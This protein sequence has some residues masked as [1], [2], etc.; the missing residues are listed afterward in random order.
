MYIQKFVNV[1]WGFTFLI[2]FAVLLWS[3]AF[4]PERISL[5]GDTL[6][7]AVDR[8]TFFYVAL[9]L[10]VIVNLAAL[11]LRR[12]L[13]ALPL[14]SAVYARNEAF[15]EQLIAWFGG[16]LSAVNVCL[17]TLVG[18]VSLA[19][20]QGSFAISSFNFLV[21]LGPVLMVGC[22]LWLAA[23]LAERRKYVLKG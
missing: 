14:S 7:P 17:I 12:M 16:L 4:L 11:I 21:Y 1:A 5:Y 9:A 15:K 20:N 10:F 18:Y 2:F 13:E 22:L 8:E 19:N 23:V 6:K 3:Y